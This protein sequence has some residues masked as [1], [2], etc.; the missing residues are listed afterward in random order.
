MYMLFQSTENRLKTKK[1]CIGQIPG[2]KTLL[3]GTLISLQQNHKALDCVLEALV[4]ITNAYFHKFKGF[5]LSTLFLKLNT[6]LV[7]K[8]HK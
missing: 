1:R 8:M 4:V 6:L 7:I 3:P 5:G 2:R